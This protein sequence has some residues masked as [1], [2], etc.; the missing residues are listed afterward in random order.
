MSKYTTN[1]TPNGWLKCSFGN[2]QT[3]KP[4][5]FCF[6]ISL[7][8]FVDTRFSFFFSHILNSTMILLHKRGE[9]TQHENKIHPISKK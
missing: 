2:Y 9:I 8:A 6:L 7:Q 5:L 4:P 3:V 1:I